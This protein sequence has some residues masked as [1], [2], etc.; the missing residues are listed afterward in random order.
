LFKIFADE[1]RLNIDFLSK[2]TEDAKNKKTVENNEIPYT[3]EEL[4]EKDDFLQKEIIK[5]NNYLNKILEPKYKP[6]LKNAYEPLLFCVNKKNLEEIVQK[7]D[8]KEL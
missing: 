2:F 4:L 6:V 7:K 3:F 5:R 1:N 8:K